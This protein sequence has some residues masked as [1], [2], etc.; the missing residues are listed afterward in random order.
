M[1]QNYN[2]KLMSPVSMYHRCQ[3][4][5]FIPFPFILFKMSP[6]CN[7]KRE[8]EEERRKDKKFS[9]IEKNVFNLEMLKKCKSVLRR[10]R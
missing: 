5:Y 4:H 9:T 1:N 8:N 10:K 7:K 6:I 3:F 2:R